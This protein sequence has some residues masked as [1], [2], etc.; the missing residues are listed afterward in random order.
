MAA[1]K[2]PARAKPKGKTIPAGTPVT[3]HY[4]GAIGHGTVAGI[5]KKGTT[6]KTTEYNV[7]E[8][9]HHVSASGSREKPVVRHYGSALKRAG[10]RGK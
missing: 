9:D 5:A 7:R 2:K 10:K 3:W 4:R 6:A 8:H 1:R